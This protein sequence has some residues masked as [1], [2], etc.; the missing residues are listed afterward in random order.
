MHSAP[1]HTPQHHH[2][3]SKRNVFGELSPCDICDTA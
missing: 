3:M 2:L 1:K